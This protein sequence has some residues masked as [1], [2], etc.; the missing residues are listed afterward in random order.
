M[1]RFA[2]TPP[3]QHPLETADDMS[4]L[5]WFANEVDGGG[6]FPSAD[7]SDGAPL[8]GGSGLD[9]EFLDAWLSGE[10]GD[11]GSSDEHGVESLLSH[12]AGFGVMSVLRSGTSP[13]DSAHLGH[14]AEG[15]GPEWTFAD[16]PDGD[17]AG[18]A[19]LGDVPL[20]PAPASG[21]PGG[22]MAGAQDLIMLD[23]GQFAKGGNAPDGKGNGGGGGGKSDG[24]PNA[25]S[26]YTSG[27]E[28]GYNIQIDF[29]GGWTA[30]LQD[31]F[32]ASADLLSSWI[33]GDI[34]DVF[35]RGKIIDDIVI[36]AE[37]KDIDGAGGILGQA[38]P[39]AVRTDGYLPATAVMQFDSAD[40]DAF[41]QV[42]QWEEIVLHE[43]V[44]SIGFGSIW[45]FLGLVDGS[46]T[47]TP[48][49]NGTAATLTYQ[50][51]F[52]A[53]GADGVPLEQDGGSGTVES[54]WD[55]ETFGAELMTGYLD[56]STSVSFD[57][58]DTGD[59]LSD[60]TLASLEDLGYDTVW[61]P[62]AALI[63]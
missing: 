30:D 15:T 27:G 3:D 12:D 40:A 58:A 55:E 9:S 31:A 4:L 39:T 19:G 17:I 20:E 44:H 42:G 61:T 2:A 21:A 5:S 33:V 48:T 36:S 28:D 57:V 35:Y 53:E 63:A 43:M 49:F 23:A 41:N 14:E 52:G 59:D 45:E 10:P 37:L 34:A 46:G 8:A 54:H 60:M 13:W 26:S 18:M 25:L 51:E 11:T 7:A 24:D 29:K 16:G 62:D 50:A 32:I 38:G 6:A 47:Q 22:E 1:S 56:S